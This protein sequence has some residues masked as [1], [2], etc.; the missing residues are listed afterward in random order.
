MDV[1]ETADAVAKLIAQSGGSTLGSRLAAGV[2]DRIES[3][4]SSLRKRFAD[5]PE[6]LQAIEQ[7][8]AGSDSGDLVAA[9]VRS[10]SA[11]PDFG[12]ELQREVEEVRRVDPTIFA[13]Q[14]TGDARVGKMINVVAPHGHVEID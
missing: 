9:L 1:V 6:T 12:A 10:A 2:I 3:L 5:E 8:R 14:V 7:A 4:Y 13:T 11:D